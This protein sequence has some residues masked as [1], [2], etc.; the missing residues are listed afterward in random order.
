[1]SPLSKLEALSGKGPVVE[2]VPNFSEGVNPARV[3]AILGAMATD[4]VYL[5]D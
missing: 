4:G 5:L 1:M 3:E 2:C